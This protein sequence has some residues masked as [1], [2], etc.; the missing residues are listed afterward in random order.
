MDEDVRALA[1]AGL[2]DVANEIVRQSTSPAAEG[3][4]TRAW[5]KQWLEVPQPALGCRRP[6]DLLDAPGGVE[7][8]ARLLGSLESGAYQ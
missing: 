4:D 7:A 8:V 6:T 2:L 1:K 3:F 5:L